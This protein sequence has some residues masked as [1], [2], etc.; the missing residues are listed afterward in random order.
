MLV[1]ILLFHVEPTNIGENMKKDQ[2]LFYELVYGNVIVARAKS[3]KKIRIYKT[4]LMASHA[5]VNRKGWKCPMLFDDR[6]FPVI[7]KRVIRRNLRL[8]ILV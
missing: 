6:V 7:K 4:A 5:V 3:E 1:P 8:G 2:K